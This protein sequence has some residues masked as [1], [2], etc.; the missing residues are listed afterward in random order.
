MYILWEWYFEFFLKRDS[1]IY[2]FISLM[3]SKIMKRIQNLKADFVWLNAEY[4][5]FKHGIWMLECRM[6]NS[7]TVS[8]MQNVTI[9]EIASCRMPR[10]YNCWGMQKTKN[11]LMKVQIKWNLMKVQIKW[12]LLKKIHRIRCQIRLWTTEFADF[13]QIQGRMC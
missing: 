7:F 3:D 13:E 4:H 12:N 1:L 9:W 2:L 5:N 11:R 6:L 10:K 8:K